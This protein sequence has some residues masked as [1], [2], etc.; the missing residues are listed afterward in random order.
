MS[1]ARLMIVVYVVTATWPVTAQE[2]LDTTGGPITRAMTREAV[3]LAAESTV[4]SD[5]TGSTC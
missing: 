4:G 3:R 1:T 2:R 5:D